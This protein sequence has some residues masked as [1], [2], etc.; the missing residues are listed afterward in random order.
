MGIF[1]CNV[2][3]FLV[4]DLFARHKVADKDCPWSLTLTLSQAV[5]STC[6]S[7]R[8]DT[9]GLRVNGLKVNNFST[10]ESHCYWGS[11][12]LKRSLSIFCFISFSFSL[13]CG[14]DYNIQV[15]PVSYVQ[16]DATTPNVVRPRML[17]VVVSV[18]AVVCKR[19]QVHYG[20]NRTHKTF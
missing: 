5:E 12:P 11:V 18:L 15:A 17:G 6:G 1:W 4:W 14:E 3:R 8:A 2:T 7:T 13:I 10:A 20:K 19:M 9:G 16:T